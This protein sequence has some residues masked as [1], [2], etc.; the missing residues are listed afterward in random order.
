MFDKILAEYGLLESASPK[1]KSLLNDLCHEFDNKMPYKQFDVSY[2]SNDGCYYIAYVA[3]SDLTVKEC[4][5]TFG[6]VL[7]DWIG[8]QKLLPTINCKVFFSERDGNGSQRAWDIKECMRDS[9]MWNISF[10]V[11]NDGDTN[12]VTYYDTQMNP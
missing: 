3:N 2:S 11:G 7:G 12:Y 6:R 1:I 9:D 10:Q 5:K 4:I 8:T